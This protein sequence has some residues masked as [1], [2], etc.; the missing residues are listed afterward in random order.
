KGRDAS[1]AAGISA[2]ALKPSVV[3]GGR[4]STPQPRALIVKR[5]EQT[6]GIDGASAPPGWQKANTGL[7]EAI[8]STDGAAKSARKVIS[9]LQHDVLPGLQQ[10]I[11]GNAKV[12]LGG[13]APED[14]DF[15]HAVYGNFPY[16]LGFVVLLTFLLLMRAFRSIVLSVKA[17]I[18]TLIS[19]GCALGVVVFIFQQGHGSDAIWGIQAT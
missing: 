16:V 5:L 8:P 1:T 7:V 9:N 10:Q 19:L 13:V 15:V 18:L 6:D 12:T 11:G 2:G 14:R 4:G 3:L 17:V